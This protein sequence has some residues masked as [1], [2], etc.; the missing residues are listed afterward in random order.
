MV[1][2]EPGVLAYTVVSPNKWLEQA[3]ITHNT[4]RA[5]QRARNLRARG[6]CLG[7]RE[8]T[9]LMSND[10]DIVIRQSEGTS[11]SGGPR[12]T[13]DGDP[14]V[15]FTGDPSSNMATLEPKIAAT[16]ACDKS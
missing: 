15:A 13:T 1:S 12:W 11:V 5:G 4:W 9:K 8:R 7:D 6:A 14:L 10:H 3:E 2:L 16:F